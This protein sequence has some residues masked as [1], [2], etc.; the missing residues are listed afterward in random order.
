LHGCRGDKTVL[1]QVALQNRGQRKVS[2]SIHSVVLEG[3]PIERTGKQ[4]GKRVR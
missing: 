4:E 3:R 2:K 1:G